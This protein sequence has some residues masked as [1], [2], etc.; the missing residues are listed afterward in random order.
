MHFSFAPFKFVMNRSNTEAFFFKKKR[1]KENIC[2]H[3]Q[4]V[5]NEF[6]KE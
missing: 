1:V 4:D 6:E 3:K 2:T 5:I